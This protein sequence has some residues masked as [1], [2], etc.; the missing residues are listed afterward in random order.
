MDKLRR[1]AAKHDIKI[2][3]IIIITGAALRLLFIGSFPPGLNQDEASAGYEAWSLLHYGTDRNG[4]SWPVL[5][6]AWGSGQ[7]VLYSYLSLPFI[8]L[9]GLNETSLRLLMGLTGSITLVVFWLTARNIRDRAFALWALLVLAVNP[10]HI[11]ACRWALES[12]LLPFMLLLG[13]YFITLTDKKSY[14]LIISAAV[15][16]FSLYAYGTAFIFLPFFLIFA[17]IILYKRK[18][19][20]LHTYIAALCVFIIISLPIALCNLRNILGYNEL[21]I[22]GTTLPKLTSTR[23]SAVTI[24]GA[25][26]LTSA[27][28]NFKGFLRI[29]IYQNDGLPWNSA[30]VF[31]LLYGPAGLLLSL[32]GLIRYIISLIKKTAAK[33][34]AYIFAALI[35]SFL[36]SFF[37]EPN[38]N[39]MNMAFIPL[40]WYQAEGIAF[41]ISIRKWAAPAIAAAFLLAAV[42]FTRY[43]YTEY[44]DIIAPYF[45]KGLGAAIKYADMLDNDGFWITYDVNM[46]YIYA[47]F[48]T[49]YPTDEFTDTVQYQ[50]PGG[51]FRWVTSFGKEKTYSFGSVPPEATICIVEARDAGDMEVLAVYGNYAVV[52]S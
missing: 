38:I 46:P 26:G 30:G 43:Y 11:Q 40:I 31:G 33:S 14:M 27:F 16:A 5:F 23:Q 34:E 29:L 7:N 51:A 36:A 35:S 42:L 37:I 28:D 50:N 47:L 19:V 13:I 4:C 10:W 24:F 17:S 18:T 15:F 2:A 52:K 22:L 20:R 9:F 21:K 8:A 41:L 3:L 44:A 39:R 6:A 25:G 32:L 48:Y 12:N 49:R 1:F 45:H